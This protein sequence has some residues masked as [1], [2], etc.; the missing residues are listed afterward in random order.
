M[1]RYVKEI[2]GAASALLILC[3]FIGIFSPIVTPKRF[4]HGSMWDAFL[5]ER[6]D[7]VDVMFFG[8]SLVYCDIIPAVIYREAGCAPYVMAGPEQIIPMTYYYVKEMY[9]T[10]SPEIVFVEVTGM[11]FPEYTNYTKVNAGNMPASPNKLDAIFN[12]SEKSERLGLLFPLYNYHDRWTDLHAHDFKWAVPDPLAGYTFLDEALDS[13]SPAERPVDFDSSVYANNLKYLK[14]IAD[15][16]EKEGSRLIFFIAPSYWRLNGRYLQMLSSDISSIKNVQFID[17]N[18]T[19]AGL[20]IDPE[21]DYYDLLHFNYRGAE[22]FSAT[23]AGIIDGY[24]FNYD[25][26]DTELWNSRLEHY[27]SLHSPTDE[28]LPPAEDPV[29]TDSEAQTDPDTPQ[30]DLPV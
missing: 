9:E 27:E 22:K 15:V 21:S 10:Q 25:D 4:T 30:P 11:F 5:Q 18:Q 7:S 1:K 17:F 12:A 16:C 14:R 23:L 29:P 19:Y 2:I 26:V 28:S 20:G 8:S 24:F 3:I 6:K 13:A